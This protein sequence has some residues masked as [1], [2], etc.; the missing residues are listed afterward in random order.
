ME[1][2]QLQCGN[3]NN[4][5]AISTEHLGAQVQCPHCQAVLQTPP[6]PSAP[7][8]AP[9]AP[10]APRQAPTPSFR[11]PEKDSIFADPEPT[12]D[13]FGGGSAAHKVEMPKSPPAPKD[14]PAAASPPS[15]PA[16]FEDSRESDGGDLKQIRQKL[17]SGKSNFTAYAFVIL[18]PYA[19]FTTL[20][21]IY[22]LMNRPSINA[23]DYLPDPNP[24]KGG[25]R[26]SRLQPVHDGDLPNKNLIA[27]NESITI[28]DLAVTPA[29]VRLTSEGNLV[30]YLKIRNKS[31]TT[32]L[33]PIS[34]EFL[35]FTEK[36]MEGFKPYTYLENPVQRLY[37][38]YLFPTRPSGIVFDGDLGPSEE[39]IFKVQ[40]LDKFQPVVKQLA[41]RTNATLTWRVQFRRGLVPYRGGQVSATAVIGVTFTPS[42]IEKEA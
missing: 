21:I 28:G 1:T 13:L 19:I 12:D 29:R 8:P 11:L 23:F 3:C 32:R 39:G 40:T 42:A 37:G 15:G 38:G 14:P 30:L 33:T 20:V 17:A 36:S 6:P 35:R 5:M 16:G 10:P 27:L 34:D 2:I 4:M 18:I 22:L 26:Q 9:P 41:G 25:P 7:A 24:A 31:S